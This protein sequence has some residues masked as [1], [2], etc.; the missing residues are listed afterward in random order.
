M[1]IAPKASAAML[2]LLLA[3]SGIVVVGGVPTVANAQDA[4]AI[5]R[6]AT[7][8]ELVV[9]DNYPALYGWLA[10]D[11]GDATT[12]KVAASACGVSDR[13]NGV[14]T[15]PAQVTQ[16]VGWQAKSWFDEEGEK[17][18]QLGYASDYETLTFESG[19]T[20]EVRSLTIKLLDDHLVIPAGSNVTF[21][22]CTFANR[23]K[24]E[25]GGKATFENC[26]FSSGTILNNGQANY[27]GS[28]Q[29]PANKGTAESAFRDLGLVAAQPALSD[30]VHGHG[31]AGATALVLSGSNADKATLVASMDQQGSGLVA[32]IDGGELKVSGTPVAAG[33]YTATVTATAPDE[34]GTGTQAASATVNITV[35]QNYTFSVEG[36]LDA[37]RTGQG[38]YQDSS[39]H[40][41]EVFVTDEAGNKQSFYDFSCSAEGAGYVLRP[42]V[43]PDGCGLSATLFNAGGKAT[44]TLS[45]TAGAAGTYQVGA[46][47]TLGSYTF[48]TNTAELRIYSGAETLKSQLTAL[49]EGTSDWGMEPYEIDRSDN[50][51]IPTWLHHIYGSHESGLYGQIGNASDA[52][53]SDTITIP[54]GADVTLE[55]IKVNSSVK[56]VVEKGAKLTLTDSVAFGPIDVNG[57]TLTMNRS[58]ATTSTITLNDG[59]TLASSEV[60]SNAQFLTD[61]RKPMPAAPE[62]VVTVNGNVTFKGENSIKPDQSQVGLE[63]NGNARVPL[64][65]SLAVTGGNGGTAPGE[66]AS[67]IRLNGGTV[68]GEGSLSATGGSYELGGS[69]VPAKAVDGSG[70]LSTGELALAGG[71]ADTI[72]GSAIDGADAGVKTIVVTTPAAGRTI[73]GGKGVNGGEDGLGEES[74]TIREVVDRPTD[75]ADPAEN[76]GGGATGGTGTGSAA[77]GEQGDVQQAG[78]SASDK[79][80]MPQTGDGSSAASTIALTGVAVAITGGLALRRRG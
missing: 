45:G 56:I 80:A 14:T 72:F 31:Y 79:A 69:G 42:Q 23:I 17:V 25:K 53:A 40:E 34:A 65:S 59:S 61:G 63:V 18:R 55:N 43:S 6:A 60:V 19:A 12:V 52:F 15:I 41:L 51:V 47:A 7:G 74:V 73:T 4:S 32:T 29:E 58:S 54:A 49:T 13:G 33:A 27:T 26:T 44:I 77:G 68:S 75:P 8:G 62:S 67:A 46:V 38:D 20:T 9:T 24:I 16:L 70:T 30:G 11:L 2:S 57:G 28:T 66:A 48:V 37:V 78:T 64:G 71:D 36:T 76:P 50:A 35:R 5:T 3:G 21:R 39:N 1:R 10:N 22:N